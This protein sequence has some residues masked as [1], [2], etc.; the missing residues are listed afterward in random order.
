M[1]PSLACS[2][3]D[4]LIGKLMLSHYDD[5]DFAQVI[6]RASKCGALLKVQTRSKAFLRSI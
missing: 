2:A 5:I 3:G 1:Q 4:C 6:A